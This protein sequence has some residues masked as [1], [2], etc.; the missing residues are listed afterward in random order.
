[1]KNFKINPTKHAVVVSAVYINEK[2]LVTQ[3]LMR[4]SKTYKEL[5]TALES[6]YTVEECDYIEG[7]F[8]LSNKDLKKFVV[9]EGISNNSLIVIMSSSRF[10]EILGTI[11][12]VLSSNNLEVALVVEDSELYENKLISDVCLN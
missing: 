4:S 3:V 9:K 8:Y 6:L 11:K 7:E 5:V 10:T 2:Q 1:M 12:E